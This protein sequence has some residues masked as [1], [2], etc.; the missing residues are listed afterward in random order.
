M[1]MS[2]NLSAAPKRGRRRAVLAVVL[3]LACG[4]LGMAMMGPGARKSPRPSDPALN[5]RPE[6]ASRTDNVIL[7]CPGRV[8][9]ANEVTGVNAAVTGILTEVRV[10]EGQRVVAGEVIA[11]I[12]CHDLKAELQA[13]LAAAESA[14]QARR[15]LLRGSREEERHIAADKLAEAEAIRRQSQAQ[16]QRM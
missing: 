4:W 14:R 9:G 1:D 2:H 6:K 11:T 5:D 16:A 15:R 12:D 3:L 8:E 7:A 13:A 10:R